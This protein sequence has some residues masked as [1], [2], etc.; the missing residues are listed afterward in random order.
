MVARR[1]EFSFGSDVARPDPGLAVPG[2][3]GGFWL[4]LGCAAAVFASLW[5]VARLGIRATLSHAV[6]CLD[7]V[8]SARLDHRVLDRIFDRFWGSG[9]L[10]VGAAPWGYDRRDADVRPAS[11]WDEESR[12]GIGRRSG[13][14]WSFIEYCVA[15]SPSGRPDF[16][17]FVNPNRS[18]NAYNEGLA[19]S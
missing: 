17:S 3:A 13:V 2:L 11:L 10:F 14:F 9:E 6:L 18:V 5:R 19:V 7:A 16:R 1:V 12:S 15:P 8:C 4:D